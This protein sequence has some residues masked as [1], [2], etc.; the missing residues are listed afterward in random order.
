[1]A[2]IGFSAAAADTAAD[3][4]ANTVA[5]VPTPARGCRS[6]R[7]SATAQIGNK[8]FGFHSYSSRT[9]YL[10]LNQHIMLVEASDVIFHFQ[11]QFLIVFFSLDDCVYLTLLVQGSEG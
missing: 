10:N 4:D 5:A 9:Y 3:A 11:F 8:D 1:M 7:P 6:A 2:D